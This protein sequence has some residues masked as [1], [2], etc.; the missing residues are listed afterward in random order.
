[1]ESDIWWTDLSYHLCNHGWLPSLALSDPHDAYGGPWGHRMAFWLLAM[2][3]FLVIGMVELMRG[4]F[5]LRVVIV[6]LLLCTSK[7]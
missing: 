4:H 2:A 7:Q 6:P 3:L 1:M 5:T